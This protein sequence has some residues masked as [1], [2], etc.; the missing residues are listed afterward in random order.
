MKTRVI[1]ICLLAMFAG[2]GCGNTESE[3]KKVEQPTAAQ[4]QSAQPPAA[5]EEAAAPKMTAWS[6]SGK[7]VETMDASGYTYCLVDNGTDKKWVAIPKIQVEIGESVS[8]ADGL[9]MA[10]FHSKA[11]NRDFEEVVFSSGIAGKTPSAT[12][13]MPSMPPPG[14]SSGGAGADSFAGA[15]KAEQGTATDQGGATSMPGGSGGKVVVPLESVKVDKATGDNAFIVGDLFEK[16]SE[17]SGKQ[18]SVRGKVVKVSR[19]IMGKNWLH[20]Q[21]GTGDASRS[22][23][24]LVVTTQETPAMGDVVTISGTVQADKDFGA[25][26][27]YDVIVEDATVAK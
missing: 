18:V 3:P 4:P 12:P 2:A 14:M 8:F 16:R 24:D 7:I 1:G 19:G 23:H 26:Y 6:F 27:K 17:L 22:T 10:N 20:I 15:V 9:V 11:L 21:D 5:Q 13:A 25:G